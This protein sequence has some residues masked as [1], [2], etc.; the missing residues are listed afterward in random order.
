MD[1]KPRSVNS[2]EECQAACQAK[3]DCLQ[4]SYTTGT[5]SMTTEVRYGNEAHIACVEYSSSAG[6]CL[7][8]REENSNETVQSGWMIDRI[9]TYIKEKDSTCHGAEDE[10]WVIETNKNS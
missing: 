6:K 8:W 5:C 7:V 1:V 4:Y 3:T 2:L 10:M 9:S